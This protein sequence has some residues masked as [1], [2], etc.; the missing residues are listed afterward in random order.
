MIVCASF[1]PCKT[2][3]QEVASIFYL[4]SVS[5]RNTGLIFVLTGWVF[6]IEWGMWSCIIVDSKFNSPGHA[7]HISTSM[8]VY[9]KQALA[10]SAGIDIKYIFTR[11]VYYFWFR[12]ASS[13]SQLIRLACSKMLPSTL[14]WNGTTGCPNELRWIWLST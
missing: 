13:L 2:N 1:L 12:W 8:R 7:Q 5:D 3:F 4:Y 14:L 10:K 6:L 11:K 9:S